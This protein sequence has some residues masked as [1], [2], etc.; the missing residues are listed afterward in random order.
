MWNLSALQSNSWKRLAASLVQS[1][2]HRFDY[3][4]LRWGPQQPAW[5]HRSRVRPRKHTRRD[6]ADAAEA[7]R[8]H[9]VN[10]GGLE[11]G[12]ARQETVIQTGSTKMA[13]FFPQVRSFR[14]G[15]PAVTLIHVK[16]GHNKGITDCY[17]MMESFRRVILLSFTWSPGKK[18][19]VADGNARY[20]WN[21]KTLSLPGEGRE[22]GEEWLSCF[23]EVRKA[24]CYFFSTE[25]WNNCQPSVGCL[26]VYIG[27]LVMF[28]EVV[29][30]GIFIWCLKGRKVR[31]PNAPYLSHN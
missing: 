31:L 21:L 17:W 8:I 25:Y 26:T 28:S 9:C 11:E 3:G 29:W 1:V 7:Q 16:R 24:N 14:A 23:F 22:G 27:V 15:P 13:T 4:S 12:R 30:G 19:R 18:G 6:H 20:H 10:T 5:L 2:Y